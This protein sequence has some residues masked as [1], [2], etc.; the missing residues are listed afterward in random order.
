[1][2]IETTIVDE[3]YLKTALG[4][5]PAFIAKHSRAMGC[6]ARKPRRFFLSQVI[7]HLEFLA[8][9]AQVKAHGHKLQHAS[10]I[11]LVKHMAN[12]VIL[13]Q[14]S[15]PKNGVVDFADYF[16]RRRSD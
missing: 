9:A 2:S 8:A 13:A 12:D 14:K 16:A 1:M 15:V 10:Q 7:A 3:L 5:S 6:F 4:L 11:R